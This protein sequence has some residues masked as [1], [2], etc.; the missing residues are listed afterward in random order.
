MR[1]QYRNDFGYH[2]HTLGMATGYR[3]IGDNGQARNLYQEVINSSGA[4]NRY[5]TQAADGLAEMTLPDIDAKISGGNYGAA[6]QSIRNFLDSYPTSKKDDFTR[7]VADI[8]DKY[9]AEGKSDEALKL[10][11]EFTGK[12]SSG[13]DALLD[14]KKVT[15]LEK[16]GDFGAYKQAVLDYDGKYRGSSTANALLA[17]LVQKWEQQGNK[18]DAAIQAIID[19]LASRG[20]SFGTARHMQ[21]AQA[22]LSRIKGMGDKAKIRAGLLR[23]AVFPDSRYSTA[24]SVIDSARDLYLAQYASPWYYDSKSRAAS[25]PPSAKGA[26]GGIKDDTAQLKHDLNTAFAGKIAEKEMATYARYDAVELDRL[27]GPSTDAMTA[28]RAVTARIDQEVAARLAWQNAGMFKKGGFKK[29]YEALVASAPT[30][31]TLEGT[32]MTKAYSQRSGGTGNGGTRVEGAPSFD[33]ANR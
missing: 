13:N 11:G 27:F 2:K 21:A 4:D 17:Q 5:K 23:M 1:R 15:I 9:V 8:V 32:F 12:Y 30:R 25:S 24:K 19:K 31:Q 14:S 26:F 10:I 6:V 29:T 16:S 22:E 3:A 28:Y 20:N 18:D 33:G 7:R